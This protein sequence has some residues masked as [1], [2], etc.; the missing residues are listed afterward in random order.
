MECAAVSKYILI[1]GDQ[2]LVRVLV[3]WSVKTQ[4]FE[5]NIF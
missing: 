4:N 5:T 3:K 1:Q 2:I